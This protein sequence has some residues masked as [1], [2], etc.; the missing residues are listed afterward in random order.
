MAGELLVPIAERAS[1]GRD[2]ANA[3][4][5]VDAPGLIALMIVILIIGM[6]IDGLFSSVSDRMRQRRGLAGS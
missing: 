3:R 4:Q 5:S 1:L 6:V 2:L